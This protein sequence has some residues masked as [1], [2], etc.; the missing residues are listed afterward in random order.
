MINIPSVF[1]IMLYPN[2]KLLKERL[3]C[4]CAFHKWA[5]YVLIQPQKKHKLSD[6]HTSCTV[7]YYKDPDSSTQLH[8]WQLLLTRWKTCI[9]SSAGNLRDEVREAASSPGAEAQ[10]WKPLNTSNTAPLWG[11]RSAVSLEIKRLQMACVHIH[12]HTRCMWEMVNKFR[13]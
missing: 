11:Q 4:P 5:L 2:K 1:C 3:L 7:T 8:E 13:P 9:K 6:V 10:E 12:T